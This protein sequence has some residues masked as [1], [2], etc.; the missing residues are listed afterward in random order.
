[1][2][3]VHAEGSIRRA[4]DQG[5]E[6]LICGGGGSRG[7]TEVGCGVEVL[8]VGL[9]VHHDLLQGLQLWNT[10]HVVV[11]VGVVV[12]FIIIIIVVVVII[13]VTIIVI[14]IMIILI[15]ITTIINIVVIMVL[16][17]VAFWLQVIF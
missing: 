14:I 10:S 6:G 11:T 2:V 5:V 16:V 8:G 17:T 12:I 3:S 9:E 4:G 1:M 15:A 7:R 13:I